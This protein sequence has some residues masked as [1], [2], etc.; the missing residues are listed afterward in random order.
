MI[1]SLIWVLWALGFYDPIIPMIRVQ[2]KESSFNQTRNLQLEGVLWSLPSACIFIGPESD[3]WQCLSITHWL[4]CLVNLPV[5]DANCLM[6]IIK[7]FLLLRG[8]VIKLNFC[9]DFEHKVWSRFWSWSLG[10]I[11]MV[12]RFLTR[13]LIPLHFFLWRDADIWLRFWS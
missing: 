1:M 4:Y 3:H 6:M 7:V 8:L 2:R 10:K 5:N 13:S 11:C 9:S 12:K